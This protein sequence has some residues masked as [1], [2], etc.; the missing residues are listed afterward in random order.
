MNIFSKGTLSPKKGVGKHKMCM[1]IAKLGSPLLGSF[2][3]V[4]SGSGP[5]HPG[6]LYLGWIEPSTALVS[7]RGRVVFAWGGNRTRMVVATTG[8][9]CHLDYLVRTK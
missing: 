9:S 8:P 6:G 3:W 1:D 5:L 4:R 7:R 2:S